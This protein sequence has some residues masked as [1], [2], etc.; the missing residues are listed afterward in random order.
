MIF[1]PQTQAPSIDDVTTT[2]TTAKPRQKASR[3]D[4]P[5]EDQP[6]EDQP[7]EDQPREDQPRE[8]QPREDQPRRKSTILDEEWPISPST[9]IGSVKSLGAIFYC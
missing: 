6:R 8:D 2:T 3:E 9:N 4:Q 5:R 7:R 1:F